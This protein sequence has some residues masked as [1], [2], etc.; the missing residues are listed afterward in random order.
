MLAVARDL[1]ALRDVLRGELC[2]SK[3]PGRVFEA[4]DTLFENPYT[5]PAYLASRADLTASSSASALAILRK[6]GVVEEVT[7]GEGEGLLCATGI[8]QAL[9]GASGKSVS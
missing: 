7:S 8:L 4:L 9:R 1:A 6:R 2:E 3:A 5:S